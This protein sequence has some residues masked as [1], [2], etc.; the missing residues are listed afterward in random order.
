MI[1]SVAYHCCDTV[2][3][4]ITRTNSQEL[5][6]LQAKIGKLKYEMRQEQTEVRI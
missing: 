5:E 4:P 6:S 1:I 3:G 2:P